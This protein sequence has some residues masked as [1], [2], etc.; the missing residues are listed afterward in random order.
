[1]FVRL[2]AE[3]TSAAFLHRE[4]TSFILKQ[5]LSDMVK[6][7]SRTSLFSTFAQQITAESSSTTAPECHLIDNEYFAAFD[8]L[9][10]IEQFHQKLIV[11][12]ST[13][14]AE[15][16]EDEEQE[17]DMKTFAQ[18]FLI[19]L[20]ES[21]NVQQTTTSRKRQ[22][23]NI[24]DLPQSSNFIFMSDN[25]HGNIFESL[26]EKTSS[27][28]SSPSSL[29][30]KR[31][32]HEDMSSILLTLDVREKRKKTSS[33]NDQP[34]ATVVIELAEPSL[35]KSEPIEQEQVR[36]FGQKGRAFLFPLNILVGDQPCHR[37]QRRTSGNQR[38]YS[39][40]FSSI[41]GHYFLL[42]VIPTGPMR[43]GTSDL[44]VV[45]LKFL[46]KYA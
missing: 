34:E 15:D 11:K 23:R 5:F 8:S 10:D 13:T 31:I 19:D 36:C 3:D 39:F 17:M 45:S 40:F 4:K 41:S 37:S 6:K 33:R 22:R 18:Q 2:V 1:M 16:E 24:R 30:F 38:T 35:I 14:Q 12:Q 20:P 7:K 28:A 46:G 29:R 27:S 32:A 21:T 25:D 43:F 26:R 44:Y 42:Q 9:N